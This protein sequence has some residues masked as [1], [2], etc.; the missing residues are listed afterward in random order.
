MSLHIVLFFSACLQDYSEPLLLNAG[1]LL[2]FRFNSY[3]VFCL[4]RGSFCI[5]GIASPGS[6][7]A[8]FGDDRGRILVP[9]HAKVAPFGDHRGEFRFLTS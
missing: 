4:F 2:V 6:C 9:Y 7:L 1:L 5:S 3:F 8:P